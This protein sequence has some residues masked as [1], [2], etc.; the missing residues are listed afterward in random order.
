MKKEAKC[1]TVQHLV[2]NQESS[3][4]LG[5]GKR[6]VK[7]LTP[8]GF[9]ERERERESTEFVYILYSISGKV[10]MSTFHIT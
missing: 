2:E 6:E 1:A 4:V 10:A 3:R 7:L 8:I 9:I 5:C